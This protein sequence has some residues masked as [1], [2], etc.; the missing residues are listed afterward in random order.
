MPPKRLGALQKNILEHIEAQ[1]GGSGDA[2]LE[3]AVDPCEFLTQRFASAPADFAA[4]IT[5]LGTRLMRLDGTWAGRRGLP[6]SHMPI[7]P[8]PGHTVDMWVSVAH[9]GFTVETNVKGK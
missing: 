7:T 6:V 2:E 1:H 5:K 3:G 4:I 8:H 9:L